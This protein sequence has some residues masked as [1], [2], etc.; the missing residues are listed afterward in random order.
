LINEIEF[1]L[2]SI[3]ICSF[4]L[5]QGIGYKGYLTKPEL[6]QQAQPYTETSFTVV[7]T[8]HIYNKYDFAHRQSFDKDFMTVRHYILLQPEPDSYY[9]GWSSMSTLIKKGL[10][11][12]SGNPARCDVV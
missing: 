9:T 11:M 5:K 3:Q 4:C 2:K 8:V 7:C 12:K 10:V 1:T 6:Q